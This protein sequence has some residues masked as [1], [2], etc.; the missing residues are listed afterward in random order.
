[1]EGGASMGVIEGYAKGVYGVGDGHGKH[2]K[3]K[4]HFSITQHIE[5]HLG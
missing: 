2:R 4:S 3:H 5:D 1:M